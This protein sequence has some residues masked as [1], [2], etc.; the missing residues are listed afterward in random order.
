VPAH[1]P[2]RGTCAACKDPLEYIETIRSFEVAC[3]TG[4]RANLDNTGAIKLTRTTYDNSLIKR[5]IHI[6]RDPLDNIVSRFHH[7]HKRHERM[8]NF[9]WIED[10]PN[11]VSGFQKW[12]RSSKGDKNLMKASWVDKALRKRLA[13]PHL[14]CVQEFFRYVQWHNNAFSLSHAMNIPTLIVHYKD[15][16]DDTHD[17]TLERLLM[18]LKLPRVEYSETLLFESA[19]EYKHYYSRDQRQ[20][21]LSFAK[22]FS[23]VDTWQELKRYTFD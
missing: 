11:N 7:E 14:P 16:N 3:R 22:E 20:S 5:A 13:D 17:D 15:Y 1:L 21:I 18:F 19:K 10:H 12:F 9:Q 23:T 8:N 4:R 2:S 6:I